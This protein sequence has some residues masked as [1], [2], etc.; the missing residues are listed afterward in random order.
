LAKESLDAT[1]SAL[2]KKKFEVHIG[3]EKNDL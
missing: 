3:W 1:L 2:N